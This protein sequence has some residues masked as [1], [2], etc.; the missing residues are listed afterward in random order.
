[1]T[2]DK[3][4]VYLLLKQEVESFW[5]DLEERMNSKKDIINGKLT[6]INKLAEEIRT[7]LGIK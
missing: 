5:K 7:E 2:I 3:L 6:Q 4:V 1:M